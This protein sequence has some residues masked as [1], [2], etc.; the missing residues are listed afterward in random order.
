M[1]G[2]KNRT[3]AQGFL[4]THA[5]VYGAFNIQRHLPS[6]GELCLLRALGICLEQGGAVTAAGLWKALQTASGQSDG[7]GPTTPGDYPRP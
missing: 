3:S 6:R 2:F 5:A 4:E 1:Q 7:S